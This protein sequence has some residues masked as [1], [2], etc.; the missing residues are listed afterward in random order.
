MANPFVFMV[1]EETEDEGDYRPGGLFPLHLGK[2][3]GPEGSSRYRISAKLGHGSYS[4][5]WLACDVVTDRS[6]AVKIVRASETERS[7]EAAILNRL[8][9]PGSDS[10]P[11][12]L[13]L[14]A[15]FKVNSVNGIHQV[16]VTEPVILLNDLLRLPGIQALLSSMSAA[17]SMEASL[18]LFT[19]S[20]GL[21]IAP[22]L[23]PANIGAA[24][25]GLERLSEVDV[26]EKCGTPSVI[27][28]V[29]FARRHDFASFPPYLTPRIDLK[30][31]LEEEGIVPEELRVRILDLGS[32]FADESQ[33]P[34][35]NAPI[36]FKAPEVAFPTLAHGNKNAP[37]DRR[38]DIWAMG[39]TIS[40]IV[41]GGIPFKHSGTPM[42]DGMAALSGDAPEAWIQYFESATYNP[43]IN[44]AYTPEVAD[45]LWAK[46]QQQLQSAGQTA[47]DAQG[48]VALLRRMLVMDPMKRPSAAELLQDP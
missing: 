36:A 24:I 30:S 37:W 4:T 31:F 48:L 44:T 16:F 1:V 17:S 47:E 19:A 6:V 28:L 9:V 5:V 18:A 25:P 10:P 7:R 39:C 11:A 23:Y 32:Y 38:A 46:T 40:Q 21:I 43:H 22:D 45:A 34:R 35:C 3:I 26:W 13:Q 20:F 2:A 12:V 14:F 27:P 29:T 33:P 15:S 8:T 41:G 42:L